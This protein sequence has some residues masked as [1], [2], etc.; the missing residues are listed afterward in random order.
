MYGSLCKLASLKAKSK[1]DKLVIRDL[2]F[3]DDAGS[4]TRS[5]G[6]IQSILDNFSEICEI[7]SLELTA[8]ESFCYLG[9]TATSTPS[10][11]EEINVWIGKT[12]SFLEA[13]T[14]KP[15]VNE[16]KSKV[17]VC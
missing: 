9:A 12:A 4:V 10:M 16:Q 1:V 6:T 7:F 5:Q 14:V 2:L 17:N 11:N 8:V 13:S 3:A 15:Q